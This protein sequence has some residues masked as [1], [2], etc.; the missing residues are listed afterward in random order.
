MMRNILI[1][2]DIDFNLIDGSAIWLSSLVE[3]LAG[4]PDHTVDVLLKCPDY[5][6]VNS[7]QLE[8]ITNVNLIDPWSLNSASLPLHLLDNGSHARLMPDVA[9]EFL[10][11]LHS[12]NEYDTII[13]RGLDVIDHLLLH[14]ILETTLLAYITDPKEGADLERLGRLHRIQRGVDG[15]L[16]QTPEAKQFILRLLAKQD[17]GRIALLPP[18]IP[19][20]LFTEVSSE[21]TIPNSLG[22]FGKFSPPYMLEEMLAALVRIR[23]Y[24]G[25]ATFHVIGDKFHNSPPR[26]GFIERVRTSFEEQKGVHWYGGMPRNEAYQQISNVAVASAWRDESFD[27]NVEMSTKILEYAALGIPILMSPSDVNVNVFGEEY[28]GWVRTEAEF[29]ERFLLITSDPILWGRLSAQVREI[30]FRFSFDHALEGL[31]GFIEHL[32]EM[33]LLLAE[34]VI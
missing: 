9:A 15:L 23:Q 1:Y 4:H 33:N 21:Y 31:L 27:D 5:R 29:I 25:G 7:A 24:R 22:Y 6:D 17:E 14:S 18:M 26:E 2:G 19:N 20:E 28:L 11:R 32:E 34:V 8:S 16:C 30:A 13:I 12:I 10:S 3:T